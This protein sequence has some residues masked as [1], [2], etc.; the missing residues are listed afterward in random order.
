MYI[1]HTSFGVAGVASMAMLHYRMRRKVTGA[2][3]WVMSCLLASVF[4]TLIQYYFVFVIDV[5]PGYIYIQYS[6]SLVV[7]IAL[8]GG[9]LV[10]MFRLPKVTNSTAVIITLCVVGIQIGRMVLVLIGPPE[11][12]TLIRFPAVVLISVYLFFLGM[13]FYRSASIEADGTVALL[14]RRLSIL[15]LIFAPASTLFYLCVYQFPVLEKLHI[16]LDF[17]YFTVWSILTIGIFLRYLS[18]PTALLEE[19]K[20]SDG[21][22]SA[23]KITPREAEVVELISHGLSNKDIADRMCVS[24]TTARTHVYNI[25]QKTGAKS[26]VELLRIVTGYR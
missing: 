13:V 1:V 23:Y 14:L 12:A 24:F 25:F 11:V 5:F 2:L 20:V 4:L 6:L 18:K 10:L 22:I 21:F 26:R 8:Y 17:F 9:L 3:L 19:G 16:S 15:T 7:A